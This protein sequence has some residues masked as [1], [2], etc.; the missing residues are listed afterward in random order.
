MFS[1]M[2]QATSLADFVTMAL[3]ASSTSIVE[4]G[5][6]PSLDGDWEAAKAE[7]V[8]GESRLKRPRSSCSNSM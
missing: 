4:P 8:S 2:A 3:I 1:P 5:R 6:S 7:M